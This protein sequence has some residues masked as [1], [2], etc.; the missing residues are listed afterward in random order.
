QRFTLTE[1]ETMLHMH[2]RGYLPT[3]LPRPRFALGQ[4]LALVLLLTLLPMTRVHPV[5][6]QSPQSHTPIAP[7]IE[8]LVEVL[9]TRGKLPLIVQFALPEGEVGIAGVTEV[10]QVAI[11]NAQQ[12]LLARLSGYEV[13]NVKAYAFIPNLALTIEDPEALAI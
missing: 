8:E 11:A 2:I 5:A 3:T 12:A 4:F 13:E 7:P 6:A 10:N 1:E 9:N